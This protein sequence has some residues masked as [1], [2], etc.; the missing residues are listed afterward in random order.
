M[1]RLVDQL[2]YKQG[3]HHED[4]SLTVMDTVRDFFCP[5]LNEVVERGS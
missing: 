1:H 3:W 5:K 4:S 2:Y